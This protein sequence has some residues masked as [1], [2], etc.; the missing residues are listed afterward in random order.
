M[1]VA[2]R[3]TAVSAIPQE[4]ISP[5]EFLIY[6]QIKENVELLTGLRGEVD[7]VSKAVT[8]GQVTVTSLP[9]QNMRQVTAQGDGFTISGDDVA[10]LA[11]V[12][13]LINDVQELAND[14]AETRSYVNAILTQL[15]GAT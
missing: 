6:S 10:G 12:V 5:Y 8:Q 9:E 14:L 13:K 15:K 7:T 1:S 11:D 2:N 3:F 4:G